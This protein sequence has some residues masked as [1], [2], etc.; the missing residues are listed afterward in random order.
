MKSLF[1]GN[2]EQKIVVKKQHSY[3]RQ[4]SENGKEENL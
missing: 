4:E 3:F 1:S 2:N